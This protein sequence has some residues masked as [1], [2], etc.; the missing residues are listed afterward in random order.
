[1]SDEWNACDTASGCALSP[2]RASNDATAS[3]APDTTTFSG[4]LTAAT[5]SEVPAIAARTRASS[6]NTAAI[7]P[8]AGSDCMSRARSAMS[9]SP[10]STSISPAMHAA[11]YSPT[12]CPSTAIGSMPQALQ[13]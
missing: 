6:A 7:A 1:M 8:P 5:H 12:L 10:S 9:R 2:S 13:V 3:R 11:T 4:P